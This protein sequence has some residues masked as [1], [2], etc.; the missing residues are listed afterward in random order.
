[1]PEIESQVC[2]RV[3]VQQSSPGT[4]KTTTTTDAETRNTIQRQINSNNAIM[5]NLGKISAFGKNISYVCGLEPFGGIATR[6]SRCADVCSAVHRLHLGLLGLSNMSR[7]RLAMSRTRCANSRAFPD[8]VECLGA[9][10]RLTWTLILIHGMIDAA[11]SRLHR[12]REA[13]GC[14]EE[15]A[16][17]H[18]PGHVR[19]AMM[20]VY[21]GI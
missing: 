16:H 10:P 20:P 1:L 21:H 18:A 15:G 11:P 8:S 19:H 13:R 5:D 9:L 17:E 6:R 3:R 4:N 7:S 12:A 14:I 2:V